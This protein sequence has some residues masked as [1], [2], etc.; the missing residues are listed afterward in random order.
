MDH[1][2]L[3]KSSIV[4]NGMDAEA[5]LQLALGLILLGR[6][7]HVICGSQMHSY[8][9]SFMA[10]DWLV[11]GTSQSQPSFELLVLNNSCMDIPRVAGERPYQGL[12]RCIR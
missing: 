11:D 5:V 3:P 6:I 4:S 8:L 1:S 10:K 2:P 12:T 7:I 9:V